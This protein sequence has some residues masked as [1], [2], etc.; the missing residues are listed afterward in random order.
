[1][2]AT[3]F[4]CLEPAL[5]QIPFTTQTIPPV[6]VASMISLLTRQSFYPTPSLD[7]TRP[8]GICLVDPESL[9]LPFVIRL[10]LSAARLSTTL[11]AS[12]KPK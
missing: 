2:I 12:R 1:M 11:L 10:R 5:L 3:L 7:P 9:S 4:L 6:Y 8:S